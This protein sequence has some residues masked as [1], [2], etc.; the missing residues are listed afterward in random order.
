MVAAHAQTAG[1]QQLPPLWGV[2]GL[3]VF[4]YAYS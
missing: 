2:N 1:S 3:R 4:L